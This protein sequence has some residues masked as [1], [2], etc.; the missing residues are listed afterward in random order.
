MSNYRLCDIATQTAF[1]FS[2]TIIWGSREGHCEDSLLHF[3]FKSSEKEPHEE[4]P[5]EG[6]FGHRKVSELYKTI[7]VKSLKMLLTVDKK[8]INDFRN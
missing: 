6:V 1:K 2:I 5:F 3:W 7:F 8:K 4:T